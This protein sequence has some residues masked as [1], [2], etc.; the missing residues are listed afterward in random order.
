MLAG[1]QSAN[2][3]TCASYTEDGGGDLGTP[4]EE[5]GDAT[6]STDASQLTTSYFTDEYHHALVY[7]PTAGDVYLAFIGGGTGGVDQDLYWTKSA[8]DGSTW[9]APTELQDAITANHIGANFFVRPGIAEFVGIVYGSTA[10]GS[11]PLAETWTY[12]EYKIR[13]LPATQESWPIPQLLRQSDIRL[14]L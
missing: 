9:D 1:D 12:H 14:R 13:D 2:D 10:S 6:G 5:N 7:D 4:T 3:I 11:P 8:N